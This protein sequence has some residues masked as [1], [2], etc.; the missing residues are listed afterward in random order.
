MVGFN[1]KILENGLRILTIPMTDNPTVTVMVL[2]EAG[3]KYETKEIN[4]ISHFL[5][6]MCF[7]GTEKRPTALMIS[8]ELDGLGSQ[9]NAFT[10]H[11]YTGYYAKSDAKH[12][13]TIFDVISDVYLHSTL[14]SA[15]IE[16]EK[17]VIIEEINMYE[18]MPQERVQEL[19]M[20]LVYGDTP[21]GWSVAGTRETVRSFTREQFVD[22]RTSHY[23]PEATTVIVA[24]NID[25]ALVIPK[26]EKLFGPIASQSRAIKEPVVHTQSAPQILLEHRKTDQAHLVLGFPGYD[27]YDP[28][29][30]ALRI[31][32]TVLG[33]GMSSRLFQK[34]REEMGVCYYAT[35]ASE[36]FTDHGLFTISVG[37]DTKRTAEVI[38]VIIEECMRLAKELVPQAELTKA[39]EYI[40]GNMKLSLESSDDFAMF[41]GMQEILRKP[42]LL[43]EEYEAKIRTVTAED[44]LNTAKEI[45]VQEQ[46]NMSLVGPYTDSDSFLKLL[47]L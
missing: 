39:K 25:E 1:K 13:D 20:K 47:K 26:I 11:E 23:V 32:A 8:H 41:Y 12:F 40:A 29:T 2:V 9:S 15:E 24:G 35:A 33:R 21:A 18:D 34:L 38:G 6:H 14:P 37:C 16:K 5:E 17:G 36:T 10:S 30:P 7:K 27:T 3:S 22:Y 45:F 4:G 44:I 42:V 43:P 31:L 28:R 19:F 46:I